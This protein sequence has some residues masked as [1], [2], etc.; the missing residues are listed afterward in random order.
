[1][2]QQRRYEGR[3]GSVQAGVVS[4]GAL[5]VGSFPLKAATELPELASEISPLGWH[6][7]ANILPSHCSLIR[8]NPLELYILEWFLLKCILGGRR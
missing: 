4:F 3:K 7:P 8:A 6:L 1:M 2:K 5:E